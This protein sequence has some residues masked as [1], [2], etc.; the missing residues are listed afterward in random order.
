[1]N[2]Y[3]PSAADEASASPIPSATPRQVVADQVRKLL[4]LQEDTVVWV[5]QRKCPD[6]GC[7]DIETVIALFSE[8]AP[9]RRLTILSPLGLITP[10][11]LTAAL[12]KA[13]WLD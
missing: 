8:Q 12:K 2:P 11:L 1:M 3:L 7:P 13:G 9:T 6:A 5:T 10:L 4:N